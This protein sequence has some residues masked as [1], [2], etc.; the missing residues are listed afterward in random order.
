VSVA[1]DDL[2]PSCNFPL[3]TIVVKTFALA[4]LDLLWS[5][6]RDDFLELLCAAL[7]LDGPV[8]LEVCL[9]SLPGHDVLKKLSQIVVVWFFF[10]LHVSAV[11]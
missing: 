7:F 3:L 6:I 11:L 5:L 8:P 4:S 2:L 10:E 1:C 9:V